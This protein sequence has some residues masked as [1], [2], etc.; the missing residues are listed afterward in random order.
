MN[1]HEGVKELEIVIAIV[2]LYLQIVKMFDL[3]QMHIVR[4]V[5][6]KNSLRNE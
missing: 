6:L 1:Q 4:I 2:L 3:H 5:A